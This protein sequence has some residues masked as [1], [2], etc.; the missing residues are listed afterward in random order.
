MSSSNPLFIHCLA[1]PVV[2]P[3]DS[4]GRCRVRGPGPTIA[5]VVGDVDARVIADFAKGLDKALGESNRTVIVDLSLAEF[6]SI[7]GMQVLAE[8]QRHADLHGLAMLLVPG[9]PG[10]R[11]VL[12]I[13]DA[14]HHFRCFPNVRA[15]VE[16]RRSELSAHVDLDYVL[17]RS[18]DYGAR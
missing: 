8:T 3:V 18:K 9:G 12:E 1:R 11:R 2:E 15:A 17:A 16:A 4:P 13:I 5:S 7:S 6:I 14:D 10:A